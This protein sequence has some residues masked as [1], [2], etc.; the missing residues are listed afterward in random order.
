MLLWPSTGRLDGC[1]KTHDV[2]C[3]YADGSLP[4]HFDLVY[5]SGYPLLR[6]SL[7]VPRLYI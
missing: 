7:G 2:L 1:P 4:L 6:S 3:I 5:L